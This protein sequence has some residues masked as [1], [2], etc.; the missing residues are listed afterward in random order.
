MQLHVKVLCLS[1]GRLR[2]AAAWAVGAAI[3]AIEEAARDVPQPRVDGSGSRPAPARPPE[4]P[5]SP[6]VQAQ[7][8]RAFERAV[9]MRDDGSQAA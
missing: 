7:I 1:P 8:T 5:P 3:T 4:P 9:A 2:C 6:E